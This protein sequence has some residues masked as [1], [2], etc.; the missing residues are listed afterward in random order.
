MDEEMGRSVE[1]Q[2]EML[3][4]ISRGIRCD[5]QTKCAADAHFWFVFRARPLGFLAACCACLLAAGCSTVRQIRP[6]DKGESRVSLSAGGPITQVGKIYM[7]LPLI[8]AGYNYGIMEKLDAEIGVHIT[9][10]LYGI[11]KIDAGVNWRPMVPPLYSPGI[12]ISPKIFGMTDFSAGGSRLYPDLGITAYWDL[13]KYRYLYIGIENW[14]EFQTKR[15]DGNPQLNHWLFAPYTGA[16]MGNRLWQ[17]QGEVMVYTPN[18]NNQ[19]RPIKNIGLGKYGAIGVF[20]GVSRSF[21]GG[22]K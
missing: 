19:G 3:V 14:V 18:L 9:D 20:L 4:T 10:M 22:R 11:M 6:L 2:A 15:L 13:K 8:S 7:P 21:G 17:F 12:I 16:S 5:R 1:K